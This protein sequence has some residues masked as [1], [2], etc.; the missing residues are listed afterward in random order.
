M[1]LVNGF[2]PKKPVPCSLVRLFIYYFIILLLSG[3]VRRE[4]KEG[5]AEAES[6]GREEEG[7][8]IRAS[9]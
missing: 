2:F 8:F 4:E 1:M 6:G 5:E 7:T 9:S 3:W